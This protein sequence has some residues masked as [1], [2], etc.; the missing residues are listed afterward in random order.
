MHGRSSTQLLLELIEYDR[1]VEI[2]DREGIVAARSAREIDV[3]LRS[4]YQ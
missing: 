4:Q 1:R 3:C 2:R